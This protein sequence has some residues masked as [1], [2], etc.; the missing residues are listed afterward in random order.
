MAKAGAKRAANG[1]GSIKKRIINGNEYFVARYTLG[2]DPGTGRQRQKYIYAKSEGEVRKKL[3]AALHQLDTNSYIEPS[4]LT[5]GDWLDEWMLTYQVDA[6]EGTRSKYQTDILVSIKPHI[7]K[8]KLQAL[9]AHQIQKMINSLKVNHARKSLVCV[10]SVLHAALQQAYI[11]GY[12]AVNPA[13]KV[14]I[15]KGGNAKKEINPLTQKQIDDFLAVIRGSEYEMLFRVALFTGMR[16]GEVMGLQWDNIDFDNGIITIDHQLKRTKNA[17]YY[18]D[19][20]KTH[21]IR[22]IKPAASVMKLLAQQKKIQAERRLRAGELWCEGKFPGLVFTNEYG[23]HYGKNTVYH[24]V[25]KL[26]AKIGANGFRFHDLRHTFAVSYLVAGGD[27]YS[28]SKVLG[29]SNIK[30]TCDLYLHFTEDLRDQASSNMESL[31]Q[32]LA[33]L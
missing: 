17:E 29:H 20:T 27:I 19:E 24:N 5:V 3:T 26:A 16:E 33:N 8:V 28:L 9:D 11:N 13:D 1:A 31:M 7:G 21:E 6:A 30:I 15:P 25:Q 18:L 22:K 10:K 12:I 14:V 2:T 4:K 32:G 23:K